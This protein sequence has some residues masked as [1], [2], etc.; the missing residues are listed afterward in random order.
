MGY[1]TWIKDDVKY[2]KEFKTEEEGQALKKDLK[3]QGAIGIK[4]EW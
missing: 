3:Q 4:F 2:E 1:V